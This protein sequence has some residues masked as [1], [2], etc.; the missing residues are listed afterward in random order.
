[1]LPDTC[2]IRWLSSLTLTIYKDNLI[3]GDETMIVT[4]VDYD[5]SGYTLGTQTTATI[6]I[7][8]FV[9]LI[10]RDSFEN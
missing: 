6:R 8:D 9:D 10:F 3:E 1:L 5:S 2:Q 7:A 4:L